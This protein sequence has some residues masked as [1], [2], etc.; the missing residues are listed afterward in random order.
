MQPIPSR[1]PRSTNR[2]TRCGGHLHTTH[3]LPVRQTEQQMANQRHSSQVKRLLR[4][5]PRD[6]RYFRFLLQ[7]E[8]EFV[9]SFKR[10]TS[11]PMC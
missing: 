8:H 1:A 3:M 5:Y 6:A 7:E 4:I 9:A 10:L 2:R 11:G